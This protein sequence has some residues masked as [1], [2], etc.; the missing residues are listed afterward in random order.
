MVGL[1]S[2]GREWRQVAGEII[3]DFVKRNI[4]LK[5][6]ITDFYI[7]LRFFLLSYITSFSTKVLPKSYILRIVLNCFD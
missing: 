2:F 4:L 1:S 7:L 5:Q 3:Y 6:V